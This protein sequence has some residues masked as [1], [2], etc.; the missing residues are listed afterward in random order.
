MAM[1][2]LDP[3]QVTCASMSGTD[4]PGVNWEVTLMV[5][6]LVII[7]EPALVWTPMGIESL[8]EDMEMM[9]AI[10][11]QVMHGST[12]GMEAAGVSLALILM[13]KL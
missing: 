8:S 4:H 1:M 11:M 10:P 3:M 9:V 2:A 7:L 13:G 6:P 12:L 5:R